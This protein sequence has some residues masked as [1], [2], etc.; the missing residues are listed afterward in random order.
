MPRAFVTPCHSLSF[1]HFSS[2]LLGPRSEQST[3]P[4]PNPL[5][6]AQ[7]RRKPRA[8]FALA[9]AKSLRRSN[10]LTDV[11][12]A[13]AGELFTTVESARESVVYTPAPGDSHDDEEE[14]E[15]IEEETE[16]ETAEEAAA[17]VEVAGGKQDG[18]GPVVMTAAAEERVTA[19]RQVRW[20]LGDLGVWMIGCLDG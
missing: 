19:A 9:T 11:S 5:H 2:P 17:E 16:Q 3:E 12:E 6:T 8:S 7:R 15:E 1:L 14:T 10:S 4:A 18:S 13:I 20:R